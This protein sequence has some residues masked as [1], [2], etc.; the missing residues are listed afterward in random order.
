[1]HA[2]FELSG[3]AYVRPHKLG[4]AV[5]VA[6]AKTKLISDYEAAGWTVVDCEED[7]E[8]DALD[9][10]VAKGAMITLITVEPIKS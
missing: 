10:A 7:I 5:S 8:N 9:L 6:A 4:E 2:I 3:S 1:M